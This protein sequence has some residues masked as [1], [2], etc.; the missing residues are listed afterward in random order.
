MYKGCFKYL[1]L[2]VDMG[3]GALYSTAIL[4]KSVELELFGFVDLVFLVF[5]FDLFSM[6]ISHIKSYCNLMRFGFS[7]ENSTNFILFQV[8][9]LLLF[10]NFPSVP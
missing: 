6:L 5:S 2:S 3:S 1:Y 10:S 9:F 8:T 7:F 4:T